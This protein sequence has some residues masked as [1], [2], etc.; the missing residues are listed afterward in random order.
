MVGAGAADDALLAMRA[1]TTPPHTAMAAMQQ[2]MRQE[3]AEGGPSLF[4]GTR[5]CT[6]S[7][8][9][10]SVFVA[11]TTSAGRPQVVFLVNV[12]K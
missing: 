9:T 6:S 7:K 8:A 4:L 2:T 11:E 3:Y 1:A 5:T 10:P 12:L